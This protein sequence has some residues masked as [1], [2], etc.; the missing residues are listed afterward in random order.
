MGQS[1]SREVIV[2]APGD[3]RP[4][5]S[6]KFLLPT[7]SG[8]IE[9]FLVNFRGE[10]HAYVNRCGHVPLTLDWV[11]NR[12]LDDAGEYIVC[13]T[14]GGLYRPDTGE[15]IAGPPFGKFLIR[16]PLRIEA[17]RVVATVPPELL[18]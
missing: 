9:G 17:D 1:G 13:S 7:A 14:H 4:G 3:L 12:F 16:V 15:C 10:V 8:A 5:E 11:E 18:V 2:G 6:R